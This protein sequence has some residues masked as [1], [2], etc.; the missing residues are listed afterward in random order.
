MIVQVGKEAL[1][2]IYTDERVEGDDG[3]GSVG[4]LYRAI[5][6]RAR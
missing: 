3:T 4:P 6:E 5:V 2:R 1:L